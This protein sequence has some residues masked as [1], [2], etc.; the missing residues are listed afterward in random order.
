MIQLFHVSKSYQVDQPV[1]VDINLQVEKGDF[2]YLTGSSGAG[3]T[4]LLQLIFCDIQPTDGQ[5]LVM[6]RNVSRISPGSIPFLRR[7]IGVVFQD[8]RLLP[9]R[10]VYENVALPLEVLYRP[11]RDIDRRV[12]LMLKNVGLSHRMRAYPEE[13][14]GGEQQR[15]AVAR[16]LINEPA[17]LLA[18]EP[19][20]NLDEDT[21]Q[22][23]IRLFNEANARGTTVLLATHDRRLYEKTG[24][25]AVRLED[26]RAV[27]DSEI[28]LEQQEA[29]A[30]AAAS[31]VGRRR[32]ER[33]RG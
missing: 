8:F 33:G 26:G 5:V 17:I 31:A 15:V 10:S 25:R 12:R 1:L 14:S 21:T 13:L 29:R 7:K 19:T 20:G 16:A 27:F 32:S 28:K 4:T 6:G 24:R 9:R 23:I 3:K 11:K 22:D 2:L 18:D 30:Q